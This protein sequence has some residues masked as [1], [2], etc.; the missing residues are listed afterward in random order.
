MLF[1]SHNMAAITSLCS[2]ALLLERGK[3][4][5]HGDVESV[6]QKYFAKLPQMLGKSVQSNGV[7]LEVR[8]CSLRYVLGKPFLDVDFKFASEQI[9]Q[10]SIEFIIMDH[11]GSPVALL[12]SGTFFPEAIL[13]AKNQ[14]AQYM[15]TYDM[16]SFANGTYQIKAQAVKPLEK[17]F[18]CIEQV[19]EIAVERMP[20]AGASAWMRNSWGSGSIV[21]APEDAAGVPTGA[22]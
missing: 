15:R 7:T 11:Y 17:V 8:S 22:R 19:A 18:A 16:S 10:F 13:S 4:V 21:I 20:E 6:T 5:S 2:Y 3:T 1:V 12:D 9:G 14:S